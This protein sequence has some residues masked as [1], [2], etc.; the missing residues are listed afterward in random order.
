MSNRSKIDWNFHINFSPMYAAFV[1]MIFA[2]A[3]CLSP[4]STG[5]GDRRSCGSGTTKHNYKSRPTKR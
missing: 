2:V 3:V 4:K 5:R 1:W